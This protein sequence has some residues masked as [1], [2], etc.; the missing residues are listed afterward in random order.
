MGAKAN[1]NFYVASVPLL[2][3]LPWTVIGSTLIEGNVN[4]ESA[5]L[6]INIIVAISA[7]TNVF[8]VSLLK[9][10][11]KVGTIVPTITCILQLLLYSANL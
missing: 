5:S 7:F 1:Y 4:G 8:L 9:K 10:L 11:G 3:G 2:F 6:L